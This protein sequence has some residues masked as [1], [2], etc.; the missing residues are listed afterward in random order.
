ML[1]TAVG[2]LGAGF[3]LA[4]ALAAG[5]TSYALC[6]ADTRGPSFDPEAL[7]RGAKALREINASPYAKKVRVQA[8]GGEPAFAFAAKALGVFMCLLAGGHKCASR[9]CLTH[10]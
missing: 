4:A 1:R 6:D 5:G 7:E 9:Q 8:T 3:G 10:S 2:R